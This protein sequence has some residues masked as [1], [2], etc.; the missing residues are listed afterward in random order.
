[1]NQV[2]VN[3]LF[4][5]IEPLQ[6]C[7]LELESRL[8]IIISQK[9]KSNQILSE[10]KI[11]YNRIS[12]IHDDMIDSIEIAQHKVSSS[13]LTLDKYNKS[14]DL[15]KLKAEDL[16]TKIKECEFRVSI[17]ILYYSIYIYIYI[18]IHMHIL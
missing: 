4:S 2:N 1:M 6:K 3:N 5:V 17:H 7:R 13:Q 9:N 11:K 15:S 16:K 12:E 10:S 14:I 18:S 8:N